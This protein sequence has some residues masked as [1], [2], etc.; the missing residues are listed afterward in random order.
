MGCN[1]LTLAL[2]VAMQVVCICYPIVITIVD[3][4]IFV[5]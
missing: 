5:L 4:E 2:Q 3:L 1:V